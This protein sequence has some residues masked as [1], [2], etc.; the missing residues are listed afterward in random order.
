M[1]LEEV[2]I[3]AL[4]KWELIVIIWDYNDTYAENMEIIL[5]ILP[6]LIHYPAYCSFCYF[7]NNPQ[8]YGCPLAKEWGHD[9]REIDSLY[10]NWFNATLDKI[11][12]KNLA[13]QIRDSVKKIYFEKGGD[14]YENTKELLNRNSLL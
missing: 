10:D 4:L 12:A 8:C 6:E 13:E 1:K 3:S 2:Y 7:W 14:S 5:D 11:N 9:C